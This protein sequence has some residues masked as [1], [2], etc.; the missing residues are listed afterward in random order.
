MKKLIKTCRTITTS[1]T[2]KIYTGNSHRNNL[3]SL[4]NPTSPTAKG[5]TIAELLLVIIIIGILSTIGLNTYRKQ[6]EQFQF[7]DSITQVVGLIKT[8]RNYAITSRATYDPTHTPPSFIPKEGY[9][10]Y[11]DKV[12]GQFVL[13][14]NTGLLNPNT[15]ADDDIEEETYML[16]DVSSVTDIIGVSGNYAVIIFKPPLADTFLGDNLAEPS[17]NELQFEFRRRN[18]PDGSEKIIKINKIAGFPEVEL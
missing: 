4:T 16:P 6:R 7:T 8:A 17:I 3:K 18:S 12:S 10:I 2:C 5:F 9:G 13:F 11:I 15:Y 1:M 14:A